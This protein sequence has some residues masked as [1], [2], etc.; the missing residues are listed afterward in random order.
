MPNSRLATVAMTPGELA[1]EYV[2]A[3]AVLGPSW[4]WGLPPGPEIAEGLELAVE[5]V[6]AKVFEES[7]SKRKS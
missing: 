6:E 7:R 4:P 2:D 1:L 5:A 3:V